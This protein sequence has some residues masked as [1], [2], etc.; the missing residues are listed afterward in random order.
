[1]EIKIKKDCSLL[2]IEG[3]D[4]DVK[5]KTVKK[6]SQ[7]LSYECTIEEGVTIETII[8]VILKEKTFFNTLFKQD[9]NGFKIEKLKELMDKK[10]DNKE[11]V[12]YYGETLKYL[13]LSKMFELLNYKDNTN[14]I[15]L[16]PLLV[17]VGEPKEEDKDEIEEV[18]MPIGLTPIAKLKNIPLTLQKNVELFRSDENGDLNLLL[19]AVAPLTV[20]EVIVAVL[21]EITYF[22]S[23]EEKE[24]QLA[25]QLSQHSNTNKVED[26]EAYLQELVDSE[27]Y[28]KA[29]KIKKDL[30]KLKLKK[31]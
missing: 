6:L 5:E 1:M 19:T 9:L 23:D 26:L 29:A 22:G 12:N 28:E 17:G 21:F 3:F 31:K 15:D 8:N 7:Y 14:S 13:E 2:K 16:F 20:Y 27:Q 30:D 25:E 10:I 18:F 24:K 4:E 11:I